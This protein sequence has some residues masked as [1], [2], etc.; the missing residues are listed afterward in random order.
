MG[1]WVVTSMWTRPIRFDNG[2][3]SVAYAA[4]TTAHVCK[5]ESLAISLNKKMGKED[6]PGLYCA[7]I[8]TFP[9]LND[10]IEAAALDAGVMSDE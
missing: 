10:F 8:S 5:S 7:L 9:L 2:G 1:T 3:L 4:K 6:N